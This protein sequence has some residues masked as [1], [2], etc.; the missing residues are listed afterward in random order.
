MTKTVVFYTTAEGKSP[1]RDFLDLL[2]GKV[3]QKITWVLKLVEDLDSVPSGYFKKLSGTK[4]IWECRVTFGSNTY[5]IFCFFADNSL[6]VL[7]NGFIK[8]TQKIPKAE[9][10]KA[11]AYRR[12]FL[13]RRKKY[14]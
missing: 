5:R 7:T 8:K 2:S 11:E 1:V 13:K 12:D 10:E 3:A 14:E 6:I 4:D 9:I